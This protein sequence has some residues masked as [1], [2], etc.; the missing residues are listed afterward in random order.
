M[1]VIKFKLFGH[2]LDNIGFPIKGK[3]VSLNSV[4]VLLRFRKHRYVAAQ[5]LLFNSVQISAECNLVT[6]LAYKFFN[7]RN[8]TSCTV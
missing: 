7:N 2:L 4:L 1:K 3:L 6:L 5:F 8:T